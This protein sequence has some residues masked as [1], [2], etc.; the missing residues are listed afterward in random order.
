MTDAAFEFAELM[1]H[2]ISVR[3]LGTSSNY[4]GSNYDDNTKRE[5]ICLVE[6]QETVVRT[7]EGVTVTVNLTIYC[8][9]I[10][11][12][13]TEPQ[14][15]LDTDE[16]TIEAPTGYGI[17]PIASVAVYYDET[18]IEYAQVVRLT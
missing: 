12:G 4:G 8:T 17:R 5:Y 11:I 15:I 14:K 7:Q 6:D 9:T 10:P 13:K 1:P 18:G 16:V 3:S 2:K